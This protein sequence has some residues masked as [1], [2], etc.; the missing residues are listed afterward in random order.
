MLT[1]ATHETRHYFQTTSRLK[2]LFTAWAASMR[3]RKAFEDAEGYVS[4]DAFGNAL[5]LWAMEQD[6]EELAESLKPYV[7]QFLE[8]W[9][10]GKKGSDPG[11]EGLKPGRTR[12]VQD[13]TESRAKRNQPKRRN[14][15]SKQLPVRD[16]QETERDDIPGRV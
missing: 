6:Q 4:N 8:T 3:T 10:G 1:M 12:G 13:M 2:G 15:G 9:K 5:F 16:D 7:M 11:S 14:S